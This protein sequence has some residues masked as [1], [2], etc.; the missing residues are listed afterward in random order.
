VPD[1]GLLRKAKHVTS[2]KL[3]YVIV[4]DSLYFLCPLRITT[5]RQL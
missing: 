4:C 3:I 2:K 1:N 5:G